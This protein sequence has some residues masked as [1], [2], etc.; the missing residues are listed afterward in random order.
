MDEREHLRVS[1]IEDAIDD[2]R[3]GRMVILVDDE[4]RENEGDIVIAAEK[5][6]TEAVNF[7]AT[8]ARGLLCLA[9]T[10]DRIDKLKLAPMVANN[11]APLGTA[12]TVP[13]DAASGIAS[14]VSAAD[15]A[16]TIRVAI[17]EETQPEDLVTPGHVF[18]LRAREGG[19][20]V[21]S[22]QTEGSV[23]L[24]RL[25]GLK[26]AGVICEIMNPDGTMARLPALLEFGQR[27]NI[28]V[29][30]VA[31][32]IEYRMQK[33]S[34]VQQVAE[35]AMPT[36]YGE[37]VISAY[38]SSLDGAAHLVLRHGEIRPDEPVLV[39]VHRANLLSDVFGLHPSRARAKL[40]ASMR[41]IVRE[42]AGLVLYLRGEI[43]AE[44]LPTTVKAYMAGGRGTVEGP[45]IPA[46][47]F[48]EYG[49][50]A[51]ILNSMGLRRIRVLTNHAMPFRGLS[52]FG[53]EIV[54][55]VPFDES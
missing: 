3:R 54:E 34:F 1:R 6:T 39:R 37:F 40:D 47:D 12:F 26:P 7:I 10:G 41:R 36:A 8:H 44:D 17:G 20:L 28:R 31:D 9:M 51:Q 25:A 49:V 42:G 29:V 50:G 2:I 27:H 15:R 52:G 18:P 13:I 23:D 19:V 22:G 16:H 45:V 5:V 32:L 53:L 14:G 55:F 11:R 33:E 35:A 43:Q 21:R 30:T 46:M 48:R 24:A 38:Q 4:D